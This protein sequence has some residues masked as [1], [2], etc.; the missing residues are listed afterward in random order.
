MTFRNLSLGLPL[1]GLLTAC[2]GDP[3]GSSEPGVA[4]TAS[5]DTSTTV[6]TTAQEAAEGVIAELGLGAHAGVYGRHQGKRHCDVTVQWVD[7]GLSIAIHNDDNQS[8]EMTI[9]Y[10][11]TLS[12]DLGESS[13]DPG[14]KTDIN[15]FARPELLASLEADPKLQY[16]GIAKGAGLRRLNLDRITQ[17][18]RVGPGYH[19]TV[20]DTFTFVTVH[21]WDAGWLNCSLPVA[22]GN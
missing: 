9:P 1:F 7:A 8:A 12:T 19:D 10:D 22:S 17:S 21:N 11:Q 20:V 16:S 6:F 3:S 18:R 14:Y 2:G 15:V 5:A 13:R 4:R